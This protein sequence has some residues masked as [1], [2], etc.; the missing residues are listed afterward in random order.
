MKPAVI[1]SEAQAEL[2]AAIFF[3]ESRAKGLGLDLQAK[4]EQAVRAIQTKPGKLAAAQTQWLS[5]ILR[6]TI[7]LH[8]L[9]PRNA[10]LHLDRRCGARQPPPWLLDR[11]A[12]RVKDILSFL[13]SASPLNLRLIL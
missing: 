7:P 1:H 6:G 12:V 4:V 9:F 5:Q 11:S 13:L 8:H 10:R 3:Y 2:D